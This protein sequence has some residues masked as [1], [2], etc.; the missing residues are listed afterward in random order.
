MADRLNAGFTFYDEHSSLWDMEIFDY[1]FPTPEIREIKEPVPFMDGSYDF[2]FMYGE[3]TYDDRTI[4]FDARIY[5]NN[6][7]E[8]S[9]ILT[10]IKKWLLGKPIST[11]TTE[12]YENLE[13][14]MKCTKIEH[15]VKSIGLELKI[16]FVGK[17]KAL[18]IITN[19]W[20]I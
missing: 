16:T 8:R 20:V 13:F 9:V 14:Q 19:E 3:P 4:T 5:C 6:Y 1:D 11:L 10:D 18:D 7:Q 12:F 15:T 2:T 17:P